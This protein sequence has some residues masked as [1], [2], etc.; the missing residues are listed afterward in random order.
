M[1]IKAIPQVYKGNSMRSHLEVRWAKF[2]DEHNIEWIY[3]VQGANM[4]GLWY[5]PDFYLPGFKT[6]LEIKGLMEEESEEKIRRLAREV[7]RRGK[8]VCVGYEVGE[9]NLV[10]PC[11]ISYEV[12]VAPIG[13]LLKILIL[14]NYRDNQTRFRLLDLLLGEH[15][16]N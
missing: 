2:L 3:E 7:F 1:S 6:Y 8:Y 11:A 9:L 5:L 12:I 10:N 15:T 16:Y 4:D 13:E 14:L